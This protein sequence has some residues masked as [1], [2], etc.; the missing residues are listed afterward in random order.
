VI[1]DFN[2]PNP[3]ELAVEFGDVDTGPSLDDGLCC[4][5]GKTEN[6][7]PGAQTGYFTRESSAYLWL[8]NKYFIYTVNPFI[9]QPMLNLAING[10][11][12]SSSKCCK[13]KDRS[14]EDNI[15]LSEGE[16]RVMDFAG[17]PIIVT[18]NQDEA[19]YKSYTF[20]VDR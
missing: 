13:T 3:R 8:D 12:F 7:N 15:T 14:L 5:A 19:D 11:G 9:G 10:S 4:P 18:R 17:F 20:I 6:V 2:N 1:N 16:R